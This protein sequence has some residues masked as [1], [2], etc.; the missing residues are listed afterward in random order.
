VS[1]MA[2]TQL[3]PTSAGPKQPGTQDFTSDPDWLRLSF[4]AAT[5]PLMP[6]HQKLRAAWNAQAISVEQLQHQQYCERYTLA[7][8]GKRAV[9]QYYYDGKH[10]PGR[11]NAVPSALHD[12][13]LADDALIS[14]QALASTQAGSQS[15]Q[16]IQDFLDRLEATL[17]GS[18]I[19]RMGY[20]SLPYRLRVSFADDVRRGD[21]DFTY[22]G[23]ATWTA[24]QEVGGPG[25]S[26][27][28]YDEVQRLMTVNNSAPP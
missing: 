25:S 27:G 12:S 6:T 22:D 24:A 10:R 21:I 23:S 20:K 7:R 5:A 18:G 2:W 3:A 16:F 9:V 15:D 26:H 4:S 28:L 13:Q 17:G 1:D 14:L 8:G 11:A 19:R